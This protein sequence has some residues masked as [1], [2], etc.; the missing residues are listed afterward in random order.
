MCAPVVF[1]PRRDYLIGAFFFVSALIFANAG[2]I[3]LTIALL[4]FKIPLTISDSPAPICLHVFL[5]IFQF[6]ATH[7][8]LYLS[9]SFAAPLG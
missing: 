2:S 4:N 9:R 3:Y 6:S 5:W 7:R 8:D 1:I